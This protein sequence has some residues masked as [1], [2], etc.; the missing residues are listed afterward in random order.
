MSSSKNSFNW[1]LLNPFI[2]SSCSQ[3]SNSFV[4]SLSSGSSFPFPEI[5]FLKAPTTSSAMPLKPFSESYFTA[6]WP[7]KL[8]TSPPT[9]PNIPP[10]DEMLPP[11]ELIF[12]KPLN[13]PLII[14]SAVPP[15]SI[16]FLRKLDERMS[17][18]NSSSFAWAKSIEAW[19]DF[20]YSSFSSRAEP[21][22][23]VA[24]S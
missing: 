6:P 12:C 2:S 21:S 17:F 22:A 23:L 20:A 9:V 24:S 10:R 13:N 16:R 11:N 7:V 5:L 3:L 14:S 15:E 18:A 4:A 1:F 19:M 8:W